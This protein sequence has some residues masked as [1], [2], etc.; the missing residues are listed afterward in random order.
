MPATIGERLPFKSLVSNLRAGWGNY[1]REAALCLLLALAVLAAFGQVCSSNP[2]AWSASSRDPKNPA[3]DVS[4]IRNGNS[5]IKV[6]S[7]MWLAIAQPSS[8][9]NV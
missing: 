5:A 1:R 9:R 7:A 8:A 3:S 2:T 4:T 6:D